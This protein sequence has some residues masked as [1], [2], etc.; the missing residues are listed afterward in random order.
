MSHLR[1]WAR[2][3]LVVAVSLVTLFGLTSPASAATGSAGG[4]G[5]DATA[6][7]DWV[8]TATISITYRVVDDTACDNNDVYMYLRVYIW[9]ADN[10]V[11]TLRN[12][13]GCNHG[14]GSLDTLRWAASSNIIKVRVYACVDDFAGDTCFYREYDNPNT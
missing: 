9:N 13:N 7:W 6:N 1:T 4:T 12:S 2:S 5:V 10:K 11:A 8:G 3:A 14:V